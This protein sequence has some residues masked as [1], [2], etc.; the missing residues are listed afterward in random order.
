MLNTL[1]DLFK[2][3]RE[4]KNNPVEGSMPITLQLNFEEIPIPQ[5]TSNNKSCLFILIFFLIID[6]FFNCSSLWSLLYPFESW[7]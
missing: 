3:V 1:E 6:N 7:L 5:P 2:I 4:R